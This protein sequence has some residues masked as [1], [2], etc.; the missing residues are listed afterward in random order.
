MK[1]ITCRYMSILRYSWIH[2][3]PRNQYL[4]SEMIDIH[5]NPV[6]P[7]VLQLDLGLCFYYSSGF[8]VESV[9]YC[10]GC[11]VSQ[12]SPEKKMF[13]HKKNE[14][15]CYMSFS[16]CHSFIGGAPCCSRSWSVWINAILEQ[17]HKPGYTR[18]EMVCMI[19]QRF[20]NLD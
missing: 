2:P 7:F 4:G 6:T 12:S 10:G 20:D 17:V 15:D 9:S 5:S 3:A 1:L 18:I 11:G 8:Q 14:I 13:L 19:L 16:H